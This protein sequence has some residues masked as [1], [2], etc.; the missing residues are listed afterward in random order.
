MFTQLQCWF[1]GRFQDLARDF[2]V[3]LV[4]DKPLTLAFVPK[5]AAAGKAVKQV[6]VILR[7]DERYV[8]E[9]KIEEVG[10]DV[11]VMTFEGTKLDD[12]IPASTWEI[13]SDG[14]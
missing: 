1:S 8:G 3:S 13:K 2:T 12:P 9:L 6:T 11:T 14:R 7:D 4:K 10:G 5:S